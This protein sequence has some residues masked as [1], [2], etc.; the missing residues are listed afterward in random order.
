MMSTQEL[1][2]RYTA[3]RKGRL[4][5]SDDEVF[6]LE[7]ELIDRARSLPAGQAYTLLK[8]LQKKGSVVTKNS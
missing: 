2:E 1:L 6:T 8:L 3:Y 5:V 4:Q 7:M